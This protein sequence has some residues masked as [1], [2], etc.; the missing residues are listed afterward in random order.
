MALACPLYIYCSYVLSGNSA[1]DIY[2]NRFSSQENMRRRQK[3][4]KTLRI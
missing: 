3:D 1:Q 2:C 4:V